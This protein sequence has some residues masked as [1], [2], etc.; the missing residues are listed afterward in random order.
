V[1]NESSIDGPGK[2]DTSVIA[3]REAM[4]V[5]SVGEQ[6]TNL[7]QFADELARM[8]QDPEI[9]AELSVSRE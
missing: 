9:Q 1:R 2:P 5:G 7:R 3:S 6:L 4:A 8:V